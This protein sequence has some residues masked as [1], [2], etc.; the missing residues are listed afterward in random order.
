MAEITKLLSQ[1]GSWDL[2]S[3]SKSLVSFIKTHANTMED[4][5]PWPP[6][7]RIGLIGDALADPRLSDDQSI[8]KNLLSVLRII[9]RFS[10]G[11]EALS[12]RC[13]EALLFLFKSPFDNF[14][15]FEVSGTIVNLCHLPRHATFFVSFG[16]IPLLLSSFSLLNLDDS[17][18]ASLCL[19][20]QTLAFHDFAKIECISSGVAAKVVD[21][22]SCS[23]SS[24][25]KSAAVGALHNLTSINQC[26]ELVRHTAIIEAIVS[27]L[28]SDDLIVSSAA[29][30]TLQ[31]IVRDYEC[32]TLVVKGKGIDHLCFLLANSKSVDAQ[33]G[34]LGA[35][36]NIF[37]CD[38]S[39]GVFNEVRDLL[40][41]FIVLGFLE[42]LLT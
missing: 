38:C 2:R 35:L 23:S 39:E 28:Y 24:L 4:P 33:Q 29:A 1:S 13:L 11:R 27:L 32:R 6:L 19:L 15:L 26:L 10:L 7:T 37:S 18:L 16:I 5:P 9:S 21:L 25:V 8:T 22:L 17:N 41:S 40:S 42:D 12:N 3:L 20:T 34:A 36:V 30:G 31:N 14:I